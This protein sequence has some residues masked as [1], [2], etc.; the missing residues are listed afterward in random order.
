MRKQAAGLASDGAAPIVFEQPVTDVLGVYARA[1]IVV[2]PSLTEGLPLVL[3][4]AMACG[5]PC[6]ASDCSPGVALLAQDGEAARLAA[7]GDSVSLAGA[8]EALMAE[9]A[10]RRSLGARAREAMEPYRLDEVLDRWE[11]L[12][13]DVLR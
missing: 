12:L 7:R 8:I 3:A 4:E 13:A 1:G 5:L 6:V 2:L 10:E 11:Q 9:G